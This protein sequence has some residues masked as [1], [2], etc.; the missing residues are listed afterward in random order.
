MSPAVDKSSSIDRVIPERKLRCAS[1]HFYPGGGGINVSRAIK[2][3]GG[4]SVAVYPAGGLTGKMLD[5]LL[6]REKI[7]HISIPIR[8][9]TRENLTIIEKSTGQHYRFGMPG[10]KLC[11]NEWRNCLDK[12]LSLEPLPEY[13]VASGSIPPG[14]PEDFYAKIAKEIRETK[15][16]LIVDTSGK[17]L[18]LAA[19]AGAYLLKPNMR[20]LETITRRKI[21]DES[22]QEAAARRLI[23]KCQCEV[24]VVSL[25][26]AGALLVTKDRSER[27]RAPH[28]P[29]KSKVGAGDSMVA[30]IALGLVRK[31][32][33]R[34]A[35][36]FSIAAGAAA[37]M[38]PGTE[39]CKREDVQRLYKSME[40]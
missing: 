1:P 23:Q 3:M 34:D 27:M 31:Y 22:Q 25:G 32:S 10:T 9:V 29:L 26:A 13:I 19:Q 28:V 11:S 40:K 20:E 39:L 30:G 17:A 38:T 21:N 15:A 4:V 18:D 33:L 7:D 6:S 14:V 16:R 12:L 8:G 5:N 2:K 24:V 35:V 36:R 37:V